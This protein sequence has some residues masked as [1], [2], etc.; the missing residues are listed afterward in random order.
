MSGALLSS[1][2]YSGSATTVRFV[3]FMAATRFYSCA[4]G[5]VCSDAV[6]Q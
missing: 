5:S 3:E 6:L 2:T 1:V 4:T